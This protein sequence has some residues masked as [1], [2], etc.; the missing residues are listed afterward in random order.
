[1]K[2]IKIM[3]M[4]VALLVI[5]PCFSTLALCAPLGTITGESNRFYEEIT[6]G[7]GTKT[8]VRF[9]QMNLS[10]N[11][12]SGKVL[13][14]SE[15][16][17][18]NTNLSIDVINCGT[19][20]VN[21][22]T[23]VNASKSFSKNGK[24]VLAALNGD[25]WMTGVNSNSNVT[26]SVLKTT[27]GIMMINGEV[28]ATQEFGM[29][30]YMNTSG[31]STVAAPKSA[32]GVTD[33]NQP[34]VGVPVF[35]LYVTN[36][37]KNKTVKADGLN[38]LPAW[39]SL[40]VYNHRVHTSNYALNDSYEIELQC[41]NTAFTVKGKVVATV[42]AIY[43]SGSTTRPSIGQ[44]T[45]IL[46]AR[47]SRMT[48]LSSVYSIGDKVSFDL[49]LVDDYGNTTLWQ[50]VE[51]AI[52]GHMQVIKDGRQVMFDT[53]ASEYPTSLIGIKDDGTVMFANM[54]ANTNGTYKG[55]RFKDAYTLCTELGYNSVFYL[56]GGGSASMVTLK[57]G[58]YTQRNCS[59][60]GSPRAVINAVAMVWNDTPV[61]EKQGSLAYITTKD[62]LKPYSPYFISA[63]ML[64]KAVEYKFNADTSYISGENLLRV[65][66]TTST[67]DPYFGI[68]LTL[69][70]ESIDT[71]RAKFITVKIKTNVKTTTDIAFYYMT[72]S[73]SALQKTTMPLTPSNGYIYVTFNMTT[74]QGW[75]GTLTMLRLDL[76]EGITSTQNNYA[77]IEYIA[78]SSL[79]RDT[80]LLKS[81]A[82][83][84]GSIPDY[85]EYVR[86]GSAHTFTVFSEYNTESHRVECNK[87]GFSK[88]VSHTASTSPE[89]VAPTCIST[90]IETYYC[91]DCNKMLSSTVLEKTG[92]EFSDEYTTDIHPTPLS[93]G[94]KSRHC[95]NCD[96]VTDITVIPATRVNG[97]INNDSKVNGIDSN[98]LKKIISGNYIDIDYSNADINKDGTVNALDMQ[99]I[100]RMIAGAIT[101]K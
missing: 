55:L 3:S 16:D 85:Y 14:I 19:A 99:F 63:G 29:E 69:F 43:P 22:Q 61:C 25:L 2:T 64:Q 38:R 26:K 88:A 31:A 10:G 28:W 11:Y 51:D 20:T 45:I 17:L 89:Y 5:I 87:C 97:D 4:I 32:F 27:R 65:T 95:L 7:D 101:S 90:G 12:G 94:Q 71:T 58:T 49:S 35:T 47:G 56:D 18:S 21:T 48:D 75:S 8:G 37:T 74:A 6:L 78:F 66:P 76:F 72:T 36:E 30:N 68:N 93:D 70:S 23:V 98:I 24:T 53:R 82:Y 84:L 33:T 44:N 80:S 13:S 52:G 60:D 79:P 77:D 42:K 100:V 73:G 57:D 1:M 96:A 15:C 50:D 83:P 39:D 34:L 86:C 41:D 81:G 40:V 46:T 92:H 9:T 54:S 59:S 91:R 67:V 62:E